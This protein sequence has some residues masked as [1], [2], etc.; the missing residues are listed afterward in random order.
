M[1]TQTFGSAEGL[2][3][4]LRK[5]PKEISAELRDA[6]VDI[7]RDV[8]HIASG[9]AAGKGRG[10]EYL[11]PTIRATR[12]RVPVIRL[13]GSGMLPGRRRGVVGDLLWGTEF[14]GRRR[15]KTMQFLPHLG[16]T[17]YVL[18]PTIRGESEDIDRRYSE[19][20]RDALNKAR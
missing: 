6:S 4:A 15:S 20:L 14:G 2:N 5:L 13:G 18:W 17:G 8:A 9:R 10:W 19:A 12:D 7:A 1:S 3:R 16:R 11:A